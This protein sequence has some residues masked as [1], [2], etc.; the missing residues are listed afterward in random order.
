MPEAK[1]EPQPAPQAP[2]QAIAP[3]GDFSRV[4]AQLPKAEP[5]DN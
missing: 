4:L 5:Q 2:A 1:P 3:L